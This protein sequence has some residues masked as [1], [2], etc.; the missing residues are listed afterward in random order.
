[1]LIGL[2]G[3]GKTRFSEE[4][5]IRENAEVFSSDEI[6]FEFNGEFVANG[7]DVLVELRKR[8]VDRLKIGNAIYDA[9]NVSSKRRMGAMDQFRN[10]IKECYFFS[11]P[12]VN[13]I[14]RDEQR[15]KRVGPGII[16]GMQTAF[17]VPSYTEGW[18]KIHILHEMDPLSTY[19]EGQRAELE[20][21]IF[22]GVHHDALFKG[23]QSLAPFRDIY[24]L[25]QDSSYHAFSVSRHTYYVLEH[26]LANYKG[27]DKLAIAWAALFHDTGKFATKKFK[28]S[29]RYASFLGHENVSAQ[30]ALNHLISLGYSEEF[31]L[32]VSLICLLH[33]RLL[34][35][36]ESPKAIAKLSSL[37]GQDIFD[38]LV[39]FKEADTQAK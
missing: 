20:S 39:L 22:S 9:T 30:L 34:Q 3:S 27:D 6:G 2:P 35:S 4:L 31:A 28:D 18:N 38:K 25:S 37:Y 32:Q 8:A 10:C 24:N 16:R 17:H 29:N 15:E 13:C 36:Q 5:A 23:L 19:F 11:T 14:Q 1:M 26:L 21:L 33:M 12:I 7:G